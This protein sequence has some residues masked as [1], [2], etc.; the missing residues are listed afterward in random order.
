MAVTA[1]VSRAEALVGADDR[2]AQAMQVHW[3]K[4]TV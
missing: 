1:S 4:V 3:R 2:K